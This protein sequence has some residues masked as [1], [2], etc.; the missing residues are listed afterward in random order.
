MTVS[1]VE[2]LRLAIIGVGFGAQV[3]LPAFLSIPEVRVV[4]LA[5]S[6]SGRAQRVVERIGQGLRA[7]GSWQEAVE[8]GGVDGISVAAPPHV[9]AEIVHAAL[10]A[11]K[12]VLCEKPFG[13]T[14]EE[15]ARMWDDA[16]TTG[17]ANGVGFEFRVEPGITAMKR[18]VESGEIGAVRRI[19]VRWLTAGGLSPSARWSWR[20]DARLGGGVL[21]GFVSHVVDYVEWISRCRI[22]RVSA[23]CEIMVRERPDDQGEMRPVTAEDRCELLCDLDSG[24]VVELTVSNSSS[25]E[26]GHRIEIQGEKGRTLYLHEAPFTPD[27]MRLRVE[28]NSLGGRDV[29]LGRLPEPMQADSRIPPFR[30]LAIRFVEAASGLTVRDLP[31]FACGLR[32]RRILD[33]ARESSRLGRTILVM[34]ETKSA[35]R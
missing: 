1:P 15:A 9:Q 24:G 22:S 32:V 16:R 27:R 33:A 6:G 20:H 29:P 17:R 13:R 3:H 8:E 2:P 34:E 19:D 14:G 30:Q 23:R 31:D 21:N 4:G 35:C 25:S 7:W 18:L 12:H 26:V 10:A 5:D 11:G 28:T